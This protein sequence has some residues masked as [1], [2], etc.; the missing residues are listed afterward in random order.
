LQTDP[1]G[2]RVN[3]AMVTEAQADDLWLTTPTFGGSRASFGVRLGNTVF[4]N[5]HGLSGSGNDIP[6][7]LAAIDAGEGGAGW[8]YAVL[9]DFNRAPGSLTGRLPAN[10]NVYRPGGPTQV[11]G[12]ELDY[13]VASRYVPLYTGHAIPGISADHLPVE[14]GIIRLRAAAGYAIGSYSAYGDQERVVDISGNSSANGTHAIVYDNHNGGNQHFDFVPTADGNYTI[15]NQSTTSAWTS[16]TGR[17]QVPATTSTS[18]TARA[19]APRNGKS[20]TGAPTR[21]R[22]R[23]STCR[24]GCAWTCSTTAPATEPGPTSGRAPA[25]TTRSGRWSTSVPR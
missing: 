14:F 20:T 6:G 24:P 1:N 17:A 18:G 23:S 25:M 11:S 13:M 19:N 5:V 2:N 22:R 10:A 4:N 12:G 9:G 15:R 21:A 7:Q 16:T 3:L 8:D